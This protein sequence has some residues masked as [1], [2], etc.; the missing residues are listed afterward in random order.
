MGI[1][2]KIFNKTKEIGK[3]ILGIQDNITDKGK[4][5]VEVDKKGVGDINGS[6][7]QTS[8][9]DDHKNS[10]FA[11]DAKSKLF[12]GDKDKTS[13]EIIKVLKEIADNTSLTAK[14]TEGIKNLKPSADSSEAP[15]NKNK[16]KIKEAKKESLSGDIFL[17]G[18]NKPEK[19]ED[20]N[21]KDDFEIPQRIYNL[22][23]G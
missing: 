7:K 15:L 18:S 14:N 10:V 2:K 5:I 4:N 19:H 17:N 3:K 22:S 1:D 8:S 6:I 21:Y 23:R 13:N 9:I 16:E 11:S 20:S 12:G